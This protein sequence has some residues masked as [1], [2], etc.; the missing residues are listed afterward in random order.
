MNRNETQRLKCAQEMAVWRVR[1]TGKMHWTVESESGQ[2]F[3]LRR[4]SSCTHERLGY[5]TRRVCQTDGLHLAGFMAPLRR[6]TT[7][8]LKNL[9][10][11]QERRI[12]TAEMREETSKQGLSSP[13]GQI[14][15]RTSKQMLLKHSL[16]VTQCPNKSISVHRRG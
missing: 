2:H 11:V 6:K 14:Y 12:R 1:C 13:P 10:L 15:V 4:D 16:R 9:Q 5:W 7:R 8:I 3:V